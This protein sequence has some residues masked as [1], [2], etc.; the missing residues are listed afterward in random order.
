MKATPQG[1]RA[2]KKGGR[3]TRNSVFLLKYYLLSTSFHK[4]TISM[5]GHNSNMHEVHY[6]GNAK[7]FSYLYCDPLF[8]PTVYDLPKLSLHF[9][10][11]GS[12]DLVNNRVKI[13]FMS[14]QNYVLI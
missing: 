2:L 6:C 9:P 1:H 8:Q 5:L 7:F 13:M 12:N 11:M 10:K 14:L 4:R 3:S